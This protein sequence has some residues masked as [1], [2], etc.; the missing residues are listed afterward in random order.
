MEEIKESPESKEP[1]T[2][3]LSVPDM[4]CAGCVSKV[5]K[6][7][8]SVPGVKSADVNFADLSASVECDVSPELLIK[9]VSD[10]GYTASVASAVSDTSEKDNAELAQNPR[11]AV[12]GNGNAVAVWEQWDGARLVIWANRCR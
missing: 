9:A 11:V 7:L 10:A 6:S 12:D 4:T 2:V 3:H 5:E 8:R 1:E